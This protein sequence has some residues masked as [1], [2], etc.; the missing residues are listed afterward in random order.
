[1]DA[2]TLFCFDKKIHGVWSRDWPIAY[3]GDAG[4]LI[5]FFFL[6]GGVRHKLHVEAR[7]SDALKAT[8]APRR[9][10]GCKGTF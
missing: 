10:R 6:G 2:A 1:M 8:S 7:V 4:L 5:F 9:I 3:W